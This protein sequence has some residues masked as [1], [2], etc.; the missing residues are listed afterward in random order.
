MQ[1]IY[2][3]FITC[4]YGSQPVVHQA[5]ASMR[6]HTIVQRTDETETVILCVCATTSQEDMISLLNMGILTHCKQSNRER[7]SAHRCKTDG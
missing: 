6:A 2:S 5:I 1:Q 4:K 7:E 3:K